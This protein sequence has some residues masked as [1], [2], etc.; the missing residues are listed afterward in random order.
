MFHSHDRRQIQGHD[1]LNKGGGLLP[2][3][4]QRAREAKANGVR[5]GKVGVSQFKNIFFSQPLKPLKTAA[6]AAS[7]SQSAGMGV[8]RSKGTLLGT[9]APQASN[10]N[11]LGGGSTLLG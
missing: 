11:T 4:E 9:G 2:A 7:P 8:K 3:L 10:P 5:P 6:P 1:R